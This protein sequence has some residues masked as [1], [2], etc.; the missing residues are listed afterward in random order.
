MEFVIPGYPIIWW[1]MTKPGGGSDQALKNGL[2]CHSV[3]F[4]NDWI[5]ATALFICA[6]HLRVIFLCSLP[7]TIHVHLLFL[8]LGNTVAILF[9]KAAIILFGSHMHGLYKWFDLLWFFW[10][11]VVSIYFMSLVRGIL[12]CLL[13]VWSRLRISTTS[14][15]SAV[16]CSGSNNV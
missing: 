15:L 3:P 13:G 4:Q 10:G 7:F 14:L 2:W 1:Q 12:E 11:H 16:S 8:A 5:M 9:G 6:R